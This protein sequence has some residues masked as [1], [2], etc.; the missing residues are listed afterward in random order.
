MN[1]ISKEELRKRMFHQAF[2]VDSTLQ[3]WENGCWIRY[4]LFER[5]LAETPTVERR[6]KGKWVDSGSGWKCSNCGF[7]NEWTIHLKHCPECCADME[8]EKVA[9]C[10]RNKCYENEINGTTCEECECYSDMRGEE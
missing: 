10:D 6:P 4:E 9:T 5:T 1:L 2:E 8:K 7:Q 3:K